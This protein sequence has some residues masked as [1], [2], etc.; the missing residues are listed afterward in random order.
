MTILRKRKLDRANDHELVGIP[1][2]SDISPSLPVDRLALITEAVHG[3][4]SVDFSSELAGFNLE[5]GRAWV[6]MWHEKD[7]KFLR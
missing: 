3:S 5:E 7:Y 4:I 6:D 2:Q 1:P